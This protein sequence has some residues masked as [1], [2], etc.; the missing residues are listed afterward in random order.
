MGLVAFM[1]VK[2]NLMIQK[3]MK[4]KKGKERKKQHCPLPRLKMHCDSKGTQQ[5]SG[6]GKGSLYWPSSGF[7]TIYICLVKES[8]L[9]RSGDVPCHPSP[10]TLEAEARGPHVQIQ[11]EL[12]RFVSK[13]P[14]KTDRKPN[15]H[16][17]LPFLKR[18]FT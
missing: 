4:E 8:P 2:K 14:P 3:R 18:C 13:Q 10:C 16:Q 1:E 12:Y 6:R 7:R 9:F 17:S 15:A 5:A 11:P